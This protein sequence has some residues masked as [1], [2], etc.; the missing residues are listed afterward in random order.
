MLIGVDFD[1]T[2]VCYDEIFFRVAREE[3]LIPFDLQ[4][5]KN[6]VRD[7]LRSEGMEGLWTKMQGIVYGKRILEAKPFP[8]ALEFFQKASK[9]GEIFIISHKTRYPYKGEIFDLQKAARD[10]LNSWGFYDFLGRER[11]FFEET[12]EK[13]IKR[14]SFQKC[15][16]FIDDLSDLL[17][18]ES[19]PVAVEALLFSPVGRELNKKRGNSFVSWD[20]IHRYFFRGELWKKNLCMRI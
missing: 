20:E 7:Y 8:G 9:L 16:H 1:N 13:K 14:I 6:A 2:I 12:K 19:F 17:E 5:S 15:S 10:W 3:G 18:D 4:P 11:I